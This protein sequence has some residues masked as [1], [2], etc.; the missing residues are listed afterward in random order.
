MHVVRAALLALT[1]SAAAAGCGGGTSPQQT[2]APALPVSEQVRQALLDSLHGPSLP[3]MADAQRPRLPFTAVAGCSGPAQGGAG[4]YRCV[5][6]PRGIHG[7]RAVTVRVSSNGQWSTQPLQVEAR[8]RGHATRAAT[9][10]WGF[11]IR[12][13]K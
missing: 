10:V 2:A 11:G 4:Q 6:T 5:T 7:V 9:S 1:A 8:L 12:L 13:P 3:E